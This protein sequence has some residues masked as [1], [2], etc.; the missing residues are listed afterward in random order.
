MQDT[1]HMPGAFYRYTTIPKIM[2][3]GIVVDRPKRVFRMENEVRGAFPCAGT[4]GK[5]MVCSEFDINNILIVLLI[6]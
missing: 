3:L 5:S 4:A 2:I 6:I 1:L